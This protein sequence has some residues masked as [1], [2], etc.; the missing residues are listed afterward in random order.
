MKTLI[1]LFVMTL[2]TITICRAQGFEIVYLADPSVVV[3]H[4][5]WVQKIKSDWRATGI[6]L[7]IRWIDVENSAHVRYWGTVDSALAALEIAGLDIYVRV[8]MNFIDQSWKFTP[9]DFQTR[10]DGEYLLRPHGEMVG[11]RW[12]R[13]CRQ[14]LNSRSTVARSRQ[15]DFFKAVIHHLNSSPQRNK[16]KLIVPTISSDDESEYPVSTITSSLCNPDSIGPMMGGFSAVE[17]GAFVQFLRKK[18][19]DSFSDLLS[20]WG[21]DSAVPISNFPDI[22]SKMGSFG[23]QIQPNDLHYTFRYPKGRKDW[24]DFRNRELKNFLDT[25]CMAMKT[26]NKD[27]RFGLQFGS[28]YDNLLAYRGFI[29]PTSLLESVDFVITGDIPESKPNFQ[30]AA[31]YLRSLARYWDWKKSRTSKIGFATE[32]NWPGYGNYQP[33]VLCKNWKAQVDSFYERGASVLFISH[34]GTADIA[35]P[36]GIVKKVEDGSYESEYQEWKRTLESYT[37]PLRRRPVLSNLPCRRA[38]HLSCEMGLYTRDTSPDDYLYT[39]GWTVGSES[40]PLK[41]GY[42]QLR[43]NEFPFHRF[44]VPRDRYLAN[45]AAYRGTGDIVTN[46]MLANSPTY[47]ASMYD[48]LSLTA[49][50]YVL[51]D[52]AYRALTSSS[53]QRVII[54]NA[55]RFSNGGRSEDASTPGIKNEYG[56]TRTSVSHL[57]NADAR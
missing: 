38:T 3:S 55:T 22:G 50:S 5:K 37:N 21:A 35:V 16:I 42:A 28:L 11:N 41:A 4:P 44:I 2:M 14:M 53:L 19:R 26:I 1:H 57:T 34:W 20:V 8:S 15:I 17:K 31:D 48:T 43:F 13:G 51:P 29:D 10:F 49:S 27:F 18:Y 46:Y 36:N 24:L 33:D 6:N 32:T 25:L 23:W 47:V 40:I 39:Y 7:R 30:F 9:E 12:V 45:D 54:M 52:S 56:V